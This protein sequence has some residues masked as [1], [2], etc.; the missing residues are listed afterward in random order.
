VCLSSEQEGA[1]R[2]RPARLMTR[3]AEEGGAQRAR[4]CRGGVGGVR[5]GGR[6]HA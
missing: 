3:P 2:C 6:V 1:C 5:R 4:G